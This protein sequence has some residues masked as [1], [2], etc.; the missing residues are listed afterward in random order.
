MVP[1]WYDANSRV[2]G[3]PL[4]VSLTRGVCLCGVSKSS[5]MSKI[6]F[7]RVASVSSEPEEMMDFGGMVP[8]IS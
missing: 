7:P 4:G 3:F 6:R 1:G 2:A 5:M 8:V